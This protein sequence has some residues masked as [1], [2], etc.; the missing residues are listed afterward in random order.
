[1]DRHDFLQQ[2]GVIPR[3]IDPSA[4]TEDEWDEIGY[5]ATRH[6]PGTLSHNEYVMDCQEKLARGEWPTA[7]QY[8]CARKIHRAFAPPFED[9]RFG[10]VPAA[11]IV[12]GE[13]AIGHYPHA[14]VCI[15]LGICG[16]SEYAQPGYGPRW[17]FVIH[18]DGSCHLEYPMDARVLDVLDSDGPDY[19]PE[20][21]LDAADDARKRAKE[22]GK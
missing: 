5:E 15:R 22:E 16:T 10:V 1:M 17:F 4:Y 19:N 2:A 20:A 9:I 8:R 6:G 12:R 21:V 3:P 7:H 18:P 14:G 11:P 13:F